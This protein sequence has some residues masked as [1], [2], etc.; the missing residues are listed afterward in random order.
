MRKL[1]TVGLILVALLA[2]GVGAVAAQGPRG[3]MRGQNAALDTLAEVLGLEVDALSTALQDGQTVADI[4]AEQGVALD[5]VIAAVT[6]DHAEALAAAVEDGDLTQAQADAMLALHEANSE[7]RFTQA[8]PAG[9][10]ARMGDNRGQGIRTRAYES[11]DAIADTLG[12]STDDL[13]A[14]LQDGQTVAEVAEAQGV[15]LED[16]IAAAT[17]DASEALAEA[18]AAG[19]L[20]QEEADA[21]MV[22]LQSRM[23]D[24]L[25]S[26]HPMATR[27]GQ[28]MGN[29]RGGH[30]MDN[31]G[32]RGGWMG[33]QFGGR[34]PMQ[35]MPR[36]GMR[37]GFSGGRGN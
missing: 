11:M 29:A 27:G 31:A 4:A 23:E 13:F 6:A 34:N 24:M 19:E 32:P 21:R 30:F 16:L 14:A 7:A 20:T 3:G 28:F 1:Y 2:L 15:A 10:G 25:S 12:L 37:G 9:I 26:T 17:A 22:L 35:Q 36:G 5:D 8:I 33:Q 18:V